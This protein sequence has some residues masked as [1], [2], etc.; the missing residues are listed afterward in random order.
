MAE[1]KLSRQGFGRSSR[2]PRSQVLTHHYPYVTVTSLSLHCV[3]F[4][5]ELLK[6]S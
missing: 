2:D 3:I 6:A 1:A 4:Y 5:F